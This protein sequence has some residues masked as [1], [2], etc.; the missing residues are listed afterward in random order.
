[1]IGYMITWTTYGT[2]LQGDGRGYVKEGKV[3]GGNAKL[4]KANAELKGEVVRLDEKS[5]AIVRKAIL[6]EAEKLGQVIYSLAVCS[7]HVH[8]VVS[9]SDEMVGKVTGRYKRVAAKAL[10][11]NGFG[12]KVWTKGYDKR[13]CF[14]EGALKKRIDYVRG[15]GR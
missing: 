9:N 14:D 2:W 12:E 6:N 11:V 8:L 13:Y 3:F 15:H 1:M 4:E 7:N 10:R 5:C